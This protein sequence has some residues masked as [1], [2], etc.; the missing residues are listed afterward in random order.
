MIRAGIASKTERAMSHMPHELSQ[1]LRLS[2]SKRISCVKA[3]ISFFCGTSCTHPS[4]ENQLYSQPNDQHLCRTLFPVPFVCHRWY[5]LLPWPF[6][7]DWVPL[8]IRTGFS[9]RW[10]LCSWSPPSGI[11][12]ATDGRVPVGNQLSYPKLSKAAPIR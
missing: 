5:Y 12:Q 10:I 6:A 8:I 2:T 11:Q 7:K 9:R 4:T 3:G 1:H